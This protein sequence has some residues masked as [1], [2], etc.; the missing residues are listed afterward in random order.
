MDGDLVNDDLT[1]GYH[2]HITL[3]VIDGE[4]EAGKLIPA[5]SVAARNGLTIP[6]RLHGL[7]TFPG[8]TTSICVAAT[9]NKELTSLHHQLVT[10]V[11]PENVRDHYRPD[12]WVP[13]VTL[14]REICSWTQVGAC[15]ELSLN[16]RIVD[17]ELSS[18]ELIRFPPEVVLE[19]REL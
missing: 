11:G 2:P 12:R 10:A 4:M 9:T 3:V 18:I 14:T 16:W 7:V 13:H 1:H 15:M 6:L 5:L 17:A 8:P 19:S